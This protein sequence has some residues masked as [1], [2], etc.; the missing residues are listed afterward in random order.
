MANLPE[1]LAELKTGLSRIYDARLKGV[2]CFGSYA[3]GEQDPES[4]L[5]ILIV[6]D[7][8]DHYGSE[9]DRTSALVSAL[10]LK[11]A[12]SISRV[13]VPERDWSD[14]TSPFLRNARVEAIAA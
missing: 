10:S 12:V 8:L 3:R 14:P 1:L 7:R 13:F 2:F 9:I 5:D 4:D 6:L 11:H